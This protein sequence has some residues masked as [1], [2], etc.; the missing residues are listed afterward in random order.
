MAA[1]RTT[2]IRRFAFFFLNSELKENKK[3]LRK[4][5]EKEKKKEKKTLRG[6]KKRRKGSKGWQTKISKQST[7]QSNRLPRNDALMT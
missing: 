5:K 1:V 6:T 3:N 2:E 4:K 7:T